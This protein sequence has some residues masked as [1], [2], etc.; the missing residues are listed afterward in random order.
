M[1]KKGDIVESVGYVNLK[2]EE[3]NEWPEFLPKGKHRIAKTKS[4]GFGQ[5]IKTDRCNYWLHHNWFKYASVA[6]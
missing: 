5:L 2:K 6:Q 3:M 4:T 1:F